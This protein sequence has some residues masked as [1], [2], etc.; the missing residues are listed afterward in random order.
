MAQEK[1][2]SSSGVPLAILFASAVYDVALDK[3]A[4]STV[5]HAKTILIDALACVYAAPASLED[6]AIAVAGEQSLPGSGGSTL[7]ASG[8]NA[9]PATAALVN[10]AML[11]SR[12]LM[13]VYAG[14]DVSHPSEIIPSALAAAEVAGASGRELLE[15]MVAGLCLHV[16][17]AR[18]MPVHPYGFHHTGHAAIVAPLVI[19]RLLR[20]SREQ[21]A[22]VLNLTA[23]SL[24]VPE[25]FSRGQVTNLKTYA[26]GLQA[27]NAFTAVRQSRAGLCGSQQLLDEMAGLWS[28]FSGAPF[29]HG[30][31]ADGLKPDLVE[32]IWL[33]RF[34][35]QYALQ[36]LISAACKL[37]EPGIAERISHVQVFASRRTVERCA[38]AA[39][40]APKNAEAADH[41]LPFCICAALVDGSFSGDT[42]DKCRWQDAEIAE[43]MGKLSA[44]AV[45]NDAGYAVGPQ[46]LV[47][48]MKDG[49]ETSVAAEYPP[50]GSSWRDVAVEKL[51]CHA[52][53][54]VDADAA[55]SCINDIEDGSA[56]NLFS[57]FQTHS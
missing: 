7:I 55:I 15:A 45:S 43:L 12:D 36:P 18:E 32:Q 17:L 44:E 13:D 5:D 33:K 6:Q 38:D 46:K 4:A 19:S 16:T 14:R 27:K 47:L 24:L 22:S 11:R 39:K 53:G 41:S 30:A 56:R 25:G 3:L 52:Q 23:G 57:I 21:A 34:P 26:Y 54:R 28:K 49:T 29:N 48:Q 51:R 10:G 40:Y 1:Q 50:D 20:L 37:H 2:S 9:E 42:L 31:L 8:R 35:A